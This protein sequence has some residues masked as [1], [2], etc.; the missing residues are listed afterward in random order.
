MRTFR[1]LL[2]AA[3]LALSSAV[4]WTSL[5]QA[6]STAGGQATEALSSASEA[7]SSAAEASGQL[8]SVASGVWDSVS[9]TGNKL[10][11][12]FSGLTSSKGQD[13]GAPGTIYPTQAPPTDRSFKSLFCMNFP[14]VP[15]ICGSPYYNSTEEFDKPL[16]CNETNSNCCMESSC[17]SIPGPFACRGA[18]GRTTCVGDQ[19]S[20]ESGV[21]VQRGKCMCLSGACGASGT[22]PDAPPPV[23]PAT[24]ETTTFA[25]IFQQA[26]TAVPAASSSASD[27]FPVPSANAAYPYLQTLP[28]PAIQSVYEL[29]RRVAGF[30]VPKEDF[31]VQ[32]AL[33]TGT[34]I[35]MMVCAGIVGVR[36]LS[37][38]VRIAYKKFQAVAPSISAVQSTPQSMDAE[39][40]R[41]LLLKDVGCA[42]WGA[43]LA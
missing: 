40:Q 22:C 33:L 43:H 4:D 2:G 25:P 14:G 18:R 35:T 27:Q 37:F 28:S 29:K 8:R 21:F 7:V 20:M 9:S 1:W 16:F 19:L 13:P 17:L 31:E 3:S 23:L 26:P 38:G 6:I 42:S 34:I 5:T 10:A 12:G 15:I 11:G 39:G 41:E 30:K 36:T 32:L 24:E